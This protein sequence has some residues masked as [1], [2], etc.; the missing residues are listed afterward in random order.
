MPPSYGFDDVLHPKPG[1]G[2]GQPSDWSNNRF[3]LTIAAMP[4]LHFGTSLLIGSSVAVFGRHTLLRVVAPLYPT[5]MLLV[6]LAT[7][8]HWVLDCV[9]G[10]LVVGLGYTIN[11]VL[12]VFKPIEEWLFWL[13]RTEKPT[14]NAV[15]VKLRGE[16]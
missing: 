2:V 11:P 9:A 4:S 15:E 5:V 6:V 10:V 12:L 16:E 8:N 14:H 13:V 3:Q 7:A 1:T